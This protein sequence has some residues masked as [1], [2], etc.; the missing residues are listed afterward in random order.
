M[1]LPVKTYAL[2]ICLAFGFFWGHT[3]MAKQLRVG[4]DA[5]PFELTGS[6]GKTYRLADY[7]GKKT[8]IIAWFPKAFM[9]KSVLWTCCCQISSQW[10]Q[11]NQLK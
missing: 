10:R 9:K 11:S 8:V 1:H 6:D 3:A 2:L 5:P 7:K 4:D